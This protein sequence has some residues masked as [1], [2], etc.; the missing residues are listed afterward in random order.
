M[1]D[2]SRRIPPTTTAT[3]MGARRSVGPY[4]NV[5]LDDVRIYNRVLSADEM[6]RLYQLGAT[7]KIA[8]TITTNPDLERGLVGHW[9]FDGN[10]LR[11]N[12]VDKSGNGNTGY[13]N[14]FTSTTTKPGIIGQA[15]EF[16]GVDDSVDV[17]DDA[18]LR[19]DAG[20]EDFSVFVW[21]KKGR[22]ATNEGLVTKLDSDNDGWRLNT[23]SNNTF[24]C[25][26]NTIDV[27]SGSTITDTKWHF[28][29][30]TIDRDGNGQMYLDGV[31]N[32]SV[33]AISSEVMAT[34]AS[35]F[36]GT[37]QAGGN[38]PFDGLIDD[39]RIYNRALS[40]AEIL[41]LYQLGN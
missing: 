36:V 4:A 16:D 13:L 2:I 26:V 17:S 35:V 37:E 21:F 15:L 10:D 28:I 24:R 40:A 34:T 31:A 12:A 7:T 19:F 23:R 29:G 27:V 8:T 30:C 32:G 6:T 33:V 11:Q 22:L 5:N 25:S 9:T 38:Q 18:A 20:T 1:M 39:V 41:R 14:G 3:R